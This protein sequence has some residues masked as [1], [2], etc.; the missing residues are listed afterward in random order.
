MKIIRIIAILCTAA[1]LLSVTACGGNESSKPADDKSSVSS[2]PAVSDE[3][4]SDDSSV[5]EES[6]ESDESSESNESSKNEPID[7]EISSEG[8]NTPREAHKKPTRHIRCLRAHCGDKRSRCSSSEEV[9]LFSFRF[10]AQEKHQTD[11]DDNYKVKYK[12]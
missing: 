4:S 6:K 11:P 12:C 10:G 5:A 2:E 9:V 8:E 7:E 1:M 3:A